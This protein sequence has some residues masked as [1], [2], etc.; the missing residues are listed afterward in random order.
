MKY[1]RY[2]LLLLSLCISLCT[3]AQYNPNN[4]E[5]PGTRPWRLT[6][7]ADPAKA[8][9]FNRSSVTNHAAGEQF[10]IQA[11]DHSG[12]KFV[13]WEDE[14]GS[15]IT[16][17]RGI[18]Y[19]MPARHVTLTARYEYSPDTPD[20]PGRATIMRHLYL[21]SNPPSGGYFNYGSAN[22]V[23]SGKQVTLRAYPN[24]YYSFR[25]WTK[26][27]EIISTSAMF[28]YTMPERDAT[29]T[30]NFDYYY[31]PDN[32][33][34]PDAP[35]GSR[36]NLYAMRE[37]VLPGQAYTYSIYMEN[38]GVDATGFSLEVNFPQGFKVAQD[39]ISLTSRAANHTLKVENIDDGGLRFIVSGAAAIEGVGGK[40]LEIPIQVP[41]TVTIGNVFP[42]E[43]KNGLVF[44]SDGQQISIGVRS[45]SLQILR[46]ADEKPDSP[47]YVVTNLQTSN[48][49]VMPG[50]IVHLSWQVSNQGN[51]AGLGGWT[52][53][54][55]LLSPDGRKVGIGTISYEIS[56]LAVGAVVSRSVDIVLAQLLGIDGKVD[57]GVTVVP[58]VSSGEVADYQLNNS[59]QTADTPIT[60][61]KRLY[62]TVPQIPQQEGQVSTIRCQLSR[63]GN[64]TN[65]ETFQL[66]KLSGDDRLSM[67]ETVTIPRDQA[68]AYFYIPFSNNAV[69][70]ADSIVSFR[71]EGQDGYDAVEGS[72]IVRDDEL[73]P[74]RVSVSKSEVSEGDQFQLTVK[75]SAPAAKDLK[76]SI[77]SEHP[78][79]FR[80]PSSITIPAGQTE[81]TVDI[82]VIN[83]DLPDTDISSAFSVHA[84]GYEVAEAIVILKDDDLPV[85]TLTLTPSKVKEGDGPVS[86][87]GILRRT[88]N[89]DKKITVHLN[90]NSEGELYFSQRELQLAK[91]VEQVTFNLGPVDNTL[92]DGDRT[93]TVTAAVWISSCSCSASGQ[94]AGSVSAKLNVYDDDG[95][96]LT[97]ATSQG[98][99]REGVTTRLTVT[100]NTSTEKAQTIHITS[101]HDEMLTYNHTI[102]IPAG[103]QST[104]VEVTPLA[105]SVSGDSQ[106]IVFTA[107]AEGYSSGTCWLLVTDQTLPDAHIKQ[108]YANPDEAEIGNDVTLT[109]EV[110]NKGMADLRDATP[111]IIYRRGEKI[112][113]ARLYTKGDMAA[114]ASQLLTQAI[115]MPDA[116]GDHFYYAAVNED[117]RVKELNYTNNLSADIKIKSLSFFRAEVSTDKSAYKQGDKVLVSGQLSGRNINDATLDVYIINEGARE[118][119]RLTADSNGKFSTEWQLYP[120]QTG[121]FAVGACYPDEDTRE[122]MASFDVY[123]LA[124]ADNSYITCEVT[125]GEPYKG[126]LKL[127]NPGSLTL[128][129]LKAEILSAPEGCTATF[130]LPATLSG[131]QS[132]SLG[133]TLIGN[134][135]S[136]THEWS[137]LNVRV[138]SKEGASLV[139]LFYYYCRRAE[140]HL[141]CDIDSLNLNITKGT[142]R[143]IPL[144]LVNQGSGETGMITPVLPEG[145][146]LIS[147]TKSLKQDEEATLLLRFT[148][149]ERMK[150]N[151]PMTGTLGVNCENG[152]GLAIPFK[153]KLV[154]EEKGFLEV[155][156]CDEYTYNTTEAPHVEG[157]D[158]IIR[159]PVNNEVVAQGKTGKDGKFTLEL[160]EGYYRLE[161]SKE[162]HENYASYVFVNP[163]ATER[164]VV[165][166]GYQPITV[167]WDVEETEVEDEYSIVTN[168]Q[169]ETNVPMPV[170]KIDIPKSID[171][172]NMA[173]G[174]AVMINMKLTNLGLIRTDNVTPILPQDMEEWK[175]EALGYT[176][177]FQLMPKDSIIIP[178]RITRIADISQSSSNRRR[179][180]GEEAAETMYKTYGQCMAAMAAEYESL[181]GTSIKKNRPAEKLAMK[182]CAIAA[183][184]D[185][186]FDLF[187]GDNGPSSPG[188]GGD[189]P[190]INGPNLEDITVKKTID[191]C[192][193]CDMDRVNKFIDGMLGLLTWTG[194]LNDALNSTIDYYQDQQDP[195]K[196]TDSELV[197][198]VKNAQGDI[199]EKGSEAILSHYTKGASDI[200]GFTLDIIDL[201]DCDDDYKKNEE[202]APTRRA[203]KH[204]FVEV[205]KTIAKKYAQQLT[206]I[207]SILL[208]TF[209]DRIWYEELDEDKLAFMEYAQS[210][211]VGY[212]PTDDELLAHKPVSATLE[213]LRAYINHQNGKSDNFPTFK[214]MRQ[215]YTTFKEANDEAE[216]EGFSSMTSYFGKAY[217]DY[218]N[219][220]KEM[221]SSSV[222]ATISL[223]FENSMT[224]TRQAFRGRLKVFNGHE[225]TAMRDVRLNLEVRDMNGGIATAHEFQINA[226]SLDGFQGSLGLTD[227]WTLGSQANGTATI[228]FIPTKYAAPTEPQQYS[229]GGTLTYIDPFTGL[230]VT[231]DLYPVVL[232]VKP[233]PELDLTYFMQRDVYGDDPLTEEV[234][235]VVPAEFA[236]LI[237]NKGYG[238]ATNVRMVTQQPQIT[239]NEKGL[240]I[241]FQLVSSHVNGET[242]T[243]SFGKSI[244]NDF[245][246]IPAHSQSYAQWWL[247]SSLLGHFTDYDVNATHVTSYG[248]EDLSLLDEVTIHELIHGFTLEDGIRGFLVNDIVD[249][250]DTPDMVY[251]TNASQKSVAKAASVSINKL[252]PTEYQLTAMPSSAGWSYASLLDPTG[253]K[254]KLA[255]VIRQS[256]GKS[257]PVDNIWQT[258]YTLRDGKD[259]VHENRLHIVADI[260]EG[261]DT[262]LLM[263]ELRPGVELE[264]ES[265]KGAP[266]SDVE[267]NTA[268]KEVTVVFNK[269]IEASTFTTDDVSLQWQGRR[270]NASEIVISQ[271]SET[272]FKLDLDKLTNQSGYYVLTV[273][274]ENIKDTEGFDGAKSGQMAW[275]QV[276]DASGICSLEANGQLSVV[277]SPIPVKDR[278]LINGNFKMIQNMSV[279]SL[280]GISKL[281]MRNVKPNTYID[282]SKLK[283][284]VYIVN[285]QTELGVYRARVLKE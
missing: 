25:N 184:M 104:Y 91:G 283:S 42:V 262:Y 144:K 124:R 113:V 87:T 65:S 182:A 137:H 138:T 141:V 279:Y 64:W 231:R 29:L 75:L 94:S 114:G 195:D 217:T 280:N 170:V 220:Y 235:P 63:S 250:E 115:T 32:P 172:D 71:I 102:V 242:A 255:R 54:L 224:F 18:S 230:E 82:T 70:D 151:V 6:L 92:A 187:R 203:A 40:V 148:P 77:T 136:K 107:E 177:P 33:H 5:E 43:L 191:L 101:D 258:W 266:E 168:V 215:L 47:D 69:C 78:K 200:I 212:T 10:Y 178:I 264:V 20:E 213:Q 4:P 123:G 57:L 109:V 167:S 73:P 74:L 68:S 36:C 133:Y 21:K 214:S 22:D 119:K 278:M 97:L 226:E 93:Y 7:K 44:K 27:G 223:S 50:D 157:A 45:G 252:S 156:V 174:D 159:Q 117:Q 121:H 164:V 60:V 81:A 253:G 38:V 211:Q 272:E 236:L 251:F 2:L 31:S 234:E 83:D 55:Y 41:D 190:V 243:L 238:D 245:G 260:P 99:V 221:A 277:I 106:V 155:D 263:F 46:S 14:Q 205:Y 237:N 248:N 198:V 26:D 61:G 66:T 118:V 146:A 256:D 166:I 84:S 240:L 34:E 186:I 284:G 270:L 222:C 30:A 19:T 183:T 285:L 162:K 128:S 209:G 171:G 188:G 37:G 193:P 232:T 207:D 165:N 112:P 225:D 35:E 150:L 11:Y 149:P 239:E 108:F 216:Q 98:T 201:A 8:E 49:S 72:F 67:P 246:T 100:R 210:L 185:A 249:S 52:E 23:A 181:C 276:V 254:L 24:K 59:A 227:G 154:S 202:K 176:S 56:S 120:H 116:V 161:V 179:G 261:G 12:F 130:N 39:A 204:D 111:V 15:V 53:R 140:A 95:P 90:D 132:V 122:E 228:I 163:A 88:T 153:M 259:P 147:G 265:F 158:V 143:D 267:Q 28:V 125:A 229:F 269:P 105:N 76:L 86:V 218:E 17:E 241:D 160:T 16:T 197:Y 135:V 145:F 271:Q 13:Q 169:Y 196:E 273:F 58:A 233:S 244:A 208:H 139:L 192:D 127:I 89:I 247:T 131:G 62:L 274:T 80:F 3:R 173:V 282:V 219:N 180:K 142:T 96:A 1:N 281:Q 194:A 85:L 110:E 129:D 134:V 9:S 275:T 152:N 51:L 268:L 206:A 199:I 79:R 126:E 175:F 103:Q 48:M 189:G 257:L